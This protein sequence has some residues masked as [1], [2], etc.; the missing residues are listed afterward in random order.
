MSKGVQL[1]DNTGEK[2][3]PRPYYAVGDLYLT[4]NTTNPNL[5]FGGVW[6]LF[7]PGRCLVCVDTSQ[8]EFNTVK[9]TGGAKTHTLTVDQMP[10]HDHPA[11]D[12]AAGG[13][14]HQVY[15]NGDTNFPLISYP[16]WSGGNSGQGFSVQGSYNGFRTYTGTDGVHDHNIYVYN[17]GGGQAHN[18]LQPFITCYVWLRTA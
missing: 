11:D 14:S 5:L 16:G 9:K 18:N 1:K 13:H 10:A 3:Y 6:Q 8:T 17:R 7:G 4:T 12:S 2:V 15:V